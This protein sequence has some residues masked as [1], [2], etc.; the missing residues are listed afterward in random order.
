MMCS[1][2]SRM[3]PY[4]SW[5]A[6]PMLRSSGFVLPTAH[7]TLSLFLS[8]GDDRGGCFDVH[9]ILPLVQHVERVA[10]ETTGAAC[11]VIKGVHAAIVGVEEFVLVGEDEADGEPDHAARGHEVLDALRDLLA[12]SLDQMLVDVAHHAV[13]HCL[14]A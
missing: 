10:D 14:G 3:E 4:L 5:P 2:R 8:V 12:V 6:L 11:A 9:A 7:V 13:L 1:D